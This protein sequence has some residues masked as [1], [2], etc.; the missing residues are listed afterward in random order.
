M[1]RYN[2]H[3]QKSAA[4]PVRHPTLFGTTTVPRPPHTSALGVPG[5]RIAADAR[6]GERGAW[7]RALPGTDRSLP[8]KGADPRQRRDSQHIRR[9]FPPRIAPILTSRQH[10]NTKFNMQ[11]SIHSNFKKF[12]LHKYQYF[13]FQKVDKKSKMNFQN[14]SQTNYSGNFSWAL[15]T[16]I[17]L[18][19]TSDFVGGTVK[20]TG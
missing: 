16:V 1:P 10:F 15:R 3:T 7:R 4:S 12:F 17:F 20:N 5:E 14:F 11:V 6:L 2:I 9:H 18:P 8:G 19:K 13:V